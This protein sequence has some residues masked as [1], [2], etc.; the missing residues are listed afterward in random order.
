[1]ERFP[2]L[3]VEKACGSSRRSGQGARIPQIPRSP[4]ALGW[5]LKRMIPVLGD[6]GIRVT[7][8]RKRAGMWVTIEL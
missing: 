5:A 4:E 7:E 2:K 8:I 6:R 1:M 3:A